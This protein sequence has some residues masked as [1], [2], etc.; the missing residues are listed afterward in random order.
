MTAPRSRTE[1]ADDSFSLNDIRKAEGDFGFSEERRYLR[2]SKEPDHAELNSKNAIKAERRWGMGNVWRSA[3][4]LIPGVSDP[5]WRKSTVIEVSA[6]T[7]YWRTHIGRI[8]LDTEEAFAEGL[9]EI[10]SAEKRL[11]VAIDRFRSTANNDLASIKSFSEKLS[12]EMA[13]VQA[14][15]SQTIALMNSPEMQAAVQNAEALATA[16]C[17]LQ[18]LRSARLTLAVIDNPVTKP[19]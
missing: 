18:N 7:K 4:E 2:D 1:M 3:S 6:W 19:D 9:Q 16:L 17:A 12:K 15:M 13:R 14:Q 11:R 10:E 8:C 5:V